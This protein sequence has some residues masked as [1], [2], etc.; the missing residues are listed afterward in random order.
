MPLA[1][2]QAVA[3]YQ[4]GMR[5]LV[6]PRES[7]EQL[8]SNEW[9]VEEGEAATSEEVRQQ[10]EV[11]KRH[12]LFKAVDSLDELA[13]F[14]IP[15]FMTPAGG[16]AGGKRKQKAGSGGSSSSSRRRGGAAAVVSASVPQSD[17]DDHDFLGPVVV[18]RIPMPEMG[19]AATVEACL[20]KGL[21]N[22]VGVGVV[23]VWGRGRPARQLMDAATLPE[24]WLPLTG[25]VL[26]CLAV[27]C[28]R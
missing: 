2:W 16:R 20:V 10:W 18:L 12:L 6:L 13:A 21:E 25:G 19:Y 7:V 23:V 11:A 9:P 24:A 5:G 15:G 27:C 8:T 3:A 26:C 1:R 17:D 28:R 22:P 4:A 14:L